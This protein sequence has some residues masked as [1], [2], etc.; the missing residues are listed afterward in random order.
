MDHPLSDR[1]LYTIAK[2]CIASLTQTDTDLPDIL[3]TLFPTAQLGCNKLTL[4]ND[5]TEH[6][7][8]E[9][10]A[11][12]KKPSMSRSCNNKRIHLLQVLQLHLLFS[13]QKFKGGLML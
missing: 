2:T 5:F 11:D 6:V 3:L 12:S 1:Q 9:S 8:G 10:A 13:T 4:P 7:S